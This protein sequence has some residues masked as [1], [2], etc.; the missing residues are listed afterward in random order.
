MTSIAHALERRTG[1]WLVV[2]GA[3]GVVIATG[4]YASAP[5]DASAPLPMGISIA[6]ALAASRDSVGR[7]TAAGTIG[8]IADI[9]LVGG[10]LLLTRGPE[11]S[12]GKRLLWL[13]FAIS[14]LLFTIVDA[15]AGQVI[16]N[17]IAPPAIDISGYAVARR[18]FDVMFALGVATFGLGFI[19]AFLA[20]E[21]RATKLRWLYLATG[22]L[23]IFAF[24]LHLAGGNAAL[25]LGASV[26]LAGLL[27]VHLGY[28][29]T[30]AA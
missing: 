19:A 4:I 13:W 29:E 5:P 27:T 22:L 24:A 30:R 10:C 14:T 28:R 16:P 12:T 1:G 26:S 15:L 11:I 8:I 2:A 6:T 17:L 9:I 7:L 3:V 20:P 25:L 23:S 18:L 21:Y